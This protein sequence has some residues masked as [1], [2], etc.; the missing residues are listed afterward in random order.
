MLVVLDVHHA[1]VV[2]AFSLPG[3]LVWK[4]DWEKRGKKDAYSV[5]TMMIIVYVQLGQV[6][7]TQ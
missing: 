5:S 1:C 7:T 4:R 3:L 6:G 2:A